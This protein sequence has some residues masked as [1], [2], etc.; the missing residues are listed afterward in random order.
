MKKN[1]RFLFCVNF[2]VVR[3]WRRGK[4]K[5]VA[6]FLQLVPP[7][8]TLS[9]RYISPCKTGVSSHFNVFYMLW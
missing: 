3:L 2:D 8:N 9:F 5:R 7:G 6:G 4:T 1:V